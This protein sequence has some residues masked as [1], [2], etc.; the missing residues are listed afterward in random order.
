MPL[1]WG[2]K[3]VVVM[4]ARLR[5]LHSWDHMV[6]VNWGPGSDVMVWGTPKQVIQ[7]V[8]RAVVQSEAVVAARGKGFR[9][10]GLFYG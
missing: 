7:A 3:A 1:D 10:S 8:Q 4:W 9:A 5:R 6:E 2:W